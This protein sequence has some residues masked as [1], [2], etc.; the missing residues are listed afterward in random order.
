MTARPNVE[1]RTYIK[2]HFQEVLGKIF[3]P[4]S[5]KNYFSL[6]LDNTDPEGNNQELLTQLS[7]HFFVE[8]CTIGEDPSEKLMARIADEVEKG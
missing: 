4:Y 7:K 8:K 6:A 5:N 2:E 3:T 1:P